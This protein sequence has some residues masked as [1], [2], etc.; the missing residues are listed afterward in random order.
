M[1]TVAESIFEMSISRTEFLRRLPAAVGGDAYVEEDQ[2]L[3]Y[4][5]DQRCWR[6]CLEPLPPLRIA[7]VQLERLRVSLQF[8]NYDEPEIQLFLKRFQLYC[9]RGGG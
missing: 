2:S 5:D 7:L 8:A 6:I 4:R 1:K 9:Q 3:V